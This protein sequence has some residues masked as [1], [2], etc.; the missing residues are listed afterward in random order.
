MPTL[1]EAEIQTAILGALHSQKSADD[2][3]VLQSTGAELPRYCADMVGL[4]GDADVILLEVKELECGRR[5]LPAFDAEQHSDY[6]LLE[7]IGVPFA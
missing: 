4:L 7:H 6:L 3:A 2:G 5:I 1:R